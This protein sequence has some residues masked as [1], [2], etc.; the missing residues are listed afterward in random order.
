MEPIVVMEIGTSCVRVLVGEV[1]EDDGLQIVALGESAASGMRK[2]QLC[3]FN[4]VFECAGRALRQA[5]ETAN[6]AIDEVYLAVSGSEIEGVMTTGDV[7]VNGEEVTEE[8]V[9]LVREKAKSVALPLDRQVLH[10]IVGRYHTDTTAGVSPVGMIARQLS[11]EMLVVHGLQ[12]PM[13]NLVRVP[14]EL[15]LEVRDLMFSGL[16][17][18]LAVLTP[19]QK[20]QG[21]LLIDLGAGTTDFM[22]YHPGI[23]VDAGSLGVGGDHVTNDVATALCFSTLDAERAKSEFG[24]AVLTA[25]T[26]TRREVLKSADGSSSRS[27]KLSHLQLP[28]QLRMD[29]TFDLIRHRLQEK[30]LLNDLGAGVV[31]TGGGA[32]LKHAD[33]SASKVFGLP[34]EVSGPKNVP[35]LNH[36][37]RG[38]EYATLVGAMLYAHKDVLARA[39]EHRGVMRRFWNWICGN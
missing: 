39:N 32:K 35:G 9:R 11:V 20:K 5:E 22:V 21:V 33:Q 10:S 17:A 13:R 1:T 19:E 7:L 31:L 16:C 15:K 2:G 26:R 27:F 37:L 3:D 29:E 24:D 23:L 14:K 38:C 12:Q 30:G 36:N 25:T 6:I 18:A 34:C 28:I 4:M 8:H